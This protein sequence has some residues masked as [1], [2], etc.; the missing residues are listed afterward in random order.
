MEWSEN[1][2]LYVYRSFLQIP[3][4]VQFGISELLPAPPDSYVYRA[5]N[6][7]QPQ[8]QIVDWFDQSSRQTSPRLLLPAVRLDTAAIVRSALLR[9]SCAHS[10]RRSGRV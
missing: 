9:V 4:A 6:Y 2:S 8:T 5:R 3:S 10:C 7:Q 1:R